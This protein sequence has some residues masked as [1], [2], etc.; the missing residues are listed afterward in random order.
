M[1]LFCSTRP[2]IQ[3]RKFPMFIFCWIREQKR[4]DGQG[5]SRKGMGKNATKNLI[6]AMEIHREQLADPVRWDTE[7]L[8]KIRIPWGI[9][10]G[11]LGEKK[12]LEKGI[13]SCR[14]SL[15]MWENL[16]RRWVLESA[17]KFIYLLF[18]GNLLQE[19]PG[20]GWIQSQPWNVNGII[21]P[22]IRV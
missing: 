6:W 17:P 2:K 11:I 18:I 9:L 1:E 3:G 4:Q 7:F 20:W 13:L 10:D 19:Q 8:E 12:R 5:K 14:D 22:L 16:E 21:F 15:G